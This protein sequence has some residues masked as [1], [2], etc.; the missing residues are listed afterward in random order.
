MQAIPQASK[1]KYSQIFNSNDS[2]RTGLLTGIQA[3][4]ILIQSGLNQQILAQIWFLSDCDKDGMLTCD[5][6]ILA[7]HLIDVVRQGEYIF[8]L[9]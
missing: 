7:M 1:L 6:F 4:N 3:R 2:Q 9:F 8:G 5:E